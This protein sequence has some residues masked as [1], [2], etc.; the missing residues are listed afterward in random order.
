MNAATEYTAVQLVLDPAKC[1]D[2]DTPTPRDVI[3][4]MEAV[5]NDLA[6]HHP[7]FVVNVLLKCTVAVAA[8]FGCPAAKLLDAFR[9]EV[10]ITGRAQ[11]LAIAKE[12]GRA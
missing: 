9:E 4:A 1:G 11:A 6:S 5:L 8:A 3:S 12:G 7:E 2:D 10:Q